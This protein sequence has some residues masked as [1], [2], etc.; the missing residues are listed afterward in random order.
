MDFNTGTGKRT[1]LLLLSL[2]FLFRII[3][4]L[5]TEYYNIDSQIQQFLAEMLH[6]GVPQGQVP[7][8]HAIPTAVITALA[9]MRFFYQNSVDWILHLSNI[10][11]VSYYCAT[12][13]AIY[14]FG[15]RLLSPAAALTACAIFALNPV[16]YKF[17]AIGE[18]Y[19]GY[20]FFLVCFFAALRWHAEKGSISSATLL[21]LAIAL[22]SMSRKEGVLVYG[23]AL[24][25]TAFLPG[26]TTARARLRWI[27][28]PMLVSVAS[29][30]PWFVFLYRAEGIILNRPVTDIILMKGPGGGLS[31]LVE[32]HAMWAFGPHAWYHKAINLAGYL[33]YFLRNNIMNLGLWSIPL[34]VGLVRTA[35]DR[36]YWPLFLYIIL[37]IVSDLAFHFQMEADQAKDIGA[38]FIAYD[39]SRY[40]IAWIPAESII[41]AAGLFSILEFARGGKFGAGRLATIMRARALPIAA[42]A[43]AAIAIFMNGHDAF[44]LQKELC[45]RGRYDNVVNPILDW[46]TPCVDQRPFFAVARVLR[47]SGVSRAKVAVIAPYGSSTDLIFL[48]AFGGPQDYV[49]CSFGDYQWIKGKSVYVDGG[50]LIS[51]DMYMTDSP[52]KPTGAAYSCHELAD[53]SALDSL[54]IE[55]MLIDRSFARAFPGLL[56]TARTWTPV[57]GSDLVQLLRRPQTLPASR[58]GTAADAPPPAERPLLDLKKIGLNAP[59]L[60]RHGS[61]IV[62]GDR[63]SFFDQEGNELWH[64]VMM[65]ECF[66]PLDSQGELAVTFEK[67]GFR[68]DAAIIP[69]ERMGLLA[70]SPSSRPIAHDISGKTEFVTFADRRFSSIDTETNTVTAMGATD[71][72]AIAA[73]VMGQDRAWLLTQT[74]RSVI[75][76]LS[77]GKAVEEYFWKK[78]PG[79]GPWLAQGNAVSFCA[80]GALVSLAIPD[81]RV[82]RR[83]PIDGVCFDIAGDGDDKRLFVSTSEGVFSVSGNSLRGISDDKGAVKLSFDTGTGFL[84]AGSLDG[85]FTE[86]DGQG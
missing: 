64:R 30:M 86:W 1:L 17:T 59:A 2:V 60:S 58:N 74:G 54:G 12:L 52:G 41:A 51:S 7:L 28:W 11:S 53:P 47:E 6:A 8:S 4:S 49:T 9:A 65:Q 34:A 14:L 29:L 78:T 36:R 69:V 66:Y 84:G 20:A 24:L 82:Q 33:Y 55:Y 42:A 39:A 62:A 3:F 50:Q 61:L 25:S 22:C 38:S 31:Y 45:A 81:G 77:D 85:H 71:V 27:A 70:M 73:K 16:V 72:P 56:E 19:A 21:G 32:R 76:A 46:S 35:R 68:L 37:H 23:V 5:H 57:A 44:I 10:T 26:C 79:L 48:E 15:R 63:I 67:C 75:I 83:V 18:P 43:L 80:D 40:Q 13:A